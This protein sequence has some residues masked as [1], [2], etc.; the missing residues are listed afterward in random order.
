VSVWNFSNHCFQSGRSRTVG[1][2][3]T[4]ALIGSRVEGH[5]LWVSL[6]LQHLLVSEWK[7]SY[8]VS[9]WNFSTYC[10]QSGNLP[11]VF[12]VGLISF[13]ETSVV[14]RDTNNFIRFLV[15]VSENLHNDIFFPVFQTLDCL[16]NTFLADHRSYGVSIFFTA[17][18]S[19][20]LV[21][22]K[23]E[24]H[25]ICNKHLQN[26]PSLHT[27]CTRTSLSCL[28]RKFLRLNYIDIHKQTYLYLNL[29]CYGDNDERNCIKSESFYNFIDYWI[30]I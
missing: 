4:S 30:H 29:N 18:G 25:S 27:G 9:G 6:E 1:Q 12:S 16:W 2:F 13:Y 19:R 21:T 20:I 10:F 11:A 22:F 23:A 8:C 24:Q 5:V 7:V 14:K 17:A 3:G 15:S 26:C 28:C